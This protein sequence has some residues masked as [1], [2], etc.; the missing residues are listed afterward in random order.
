MIYFKIVNHSANTD[1][2]IVRVSHLAS[3]IYKNTPKNYLAFENSDITLINNV[4]FNFEDILKHCDSIVTLKM[5]DKVESLNAGVA[6]SIMMY[7]IFKS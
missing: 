7:E 1:N 2:E 5:T 6:G 3:T 4:W